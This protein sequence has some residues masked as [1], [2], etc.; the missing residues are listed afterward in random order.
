MLRPALHRARK[1]RALRLTDRL[2]AISPEW[3]HCRVYWHDQR[4][5]EVS[6]RQWV[7]PGYYYDST[8]GVRRLLGRDIVQA[9]A[10][11]GRLRAAWVETSAPDPAVVGQIVQA[12][13]DIIGTILGARRGR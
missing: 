6:H 12:G 1:L 11:L 7:G 9:R 2:Q 8:A 5:A 4:P 10:K 3:E 13:I